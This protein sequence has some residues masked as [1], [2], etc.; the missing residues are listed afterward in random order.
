MQ[1]I[2]NSQVDCSRVN[3]GDFPMAYCSFV[4]EENQKI[5]IYFVARKYAVY[6]FTARTTEKNEMENLKLILEQI[7]MFESDF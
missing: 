4:D 5:Q 2:I 3:S 7:V 6:A 1:K